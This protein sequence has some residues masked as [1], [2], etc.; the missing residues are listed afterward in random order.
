[1]Q[2]IVSVILVC[3]AFPAPGFA[4]PDYDRAILE[5]RDSAG[6][7]HY[8]RTRCGDGVLSA[9]PCWP[10][11]DTFD[12]RDLENPEF[13]LCTEI[14]FSMKTDREGWVFCSDATRLPGSMHTWK[15]SEWRLEP[16]ERRN[17]MQMWV[18]GMLHW[19][20]AF[21]F[22]VFCGMAALCRAGR[23]V[24]VARV[25]IGIGGAGFLFLNFTSGYVPL[26]LLVQGFLVGVVLALVL[27][28]AGRL[29]MRSRAV[30]HAQLLRSREA[31]PE[32]E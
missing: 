15:L 22:A 21:A 14:V 9:D 29:L 32:S 11:V 30:A 28:F 18:L 31:H 4:H 7:I 5:I 12:Y 27:L 20:R 3:L 16:A 23:G 10:S 1:M 6:N 25:L 19:P 26:W 2:Y 24:L 17:S 8:L 13:P